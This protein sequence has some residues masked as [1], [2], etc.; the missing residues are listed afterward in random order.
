MAKEVETTKNIEEKGMNEM[1]ETNVKGNTKGEEKIVM[2]ETTEIKGTTAK[3]EKAKKETKT[4]EKKTVKKSVETKKKATGKQAEVTGEKQGKDTAEQTSSAEAIETVK[5]DVV[6]TKICL[7]SIDTVSPMLKYF[8]A[9]LAD[10][11]KMAEKNNA[12]TKEQIHRFKEVCEQVIYEQDSMCKSYL[13]I[14]IPIYN[15]DEK[16]S[17]HIFGDGDLYSFAKRVFGI[18]RGRCAEYRKV[19]KR[20]GCIDETTGLCTGI[21]GEYK[22][23]TASQLVEMSKMTP[24]QIEQVSD[25]MTVVQM[26][27]KRLGNEEQKE[28]DAPSENTSSQKLKKK[29]YQLFKGENL[30]SYES[31]EKSLLSKL[32]EF[33]DQ[34]EAVRNIK[35]TLS[36]EE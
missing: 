36:Y 28:E 7:Q 4:D 18:S 33:T 13:K 20:F 35:I 6:D 34:H 23:Y 9:K 19:I 26:K 27:N 22:S 25:A 21:K 1:K 17:Y 16:K 2:N 15:I 29:S 3:S 32:S 12:Y 10:E 24:E 11:V 5:G 8:L 30:E 14:A 31:L